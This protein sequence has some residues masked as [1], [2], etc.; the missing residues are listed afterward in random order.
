M[1]HST[2]F[3]G[4]EVT[5]FPYSNTRV[6]SWSTNASHEIFDVLEYWIYNG[7]HRLPPA[8]SEPIIWR[9]LSITRLYDLWVFADD[10][11]IPRLGNDVID[12][13]HE[14][15][16][17][18]GY[19]PFRVEYAYEVT[20]P[21]QMLRELIID[22]HCFTHNPTKLRDVQG[23]TADLLRDCN[24]RIQERGYAELTPTRMTRVDRCRWHDHSRVGAAEGRQHT[25][26]FDWVISAG[27]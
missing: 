1:Y 12:M 26:S 8:P 24:A 14:R 6:P 3:A 10:Y 5:W 22:F 19:L 7:R 21:G 13:L 27:S 4:L 11:G 23:M 16:C 15:W 17:S 2:K 25:F 18:S 20:R 9:W